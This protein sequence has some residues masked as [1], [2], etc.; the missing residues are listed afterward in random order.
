MLLGGIMVGVANPQ[1]PASECS[2]K[3]PTLKSC[4]RWCAPLVPTCRLPPGGL[5]GGPLR[6]IARAI[7]S[8]TRARRD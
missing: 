8:F 6:G 5:D 3:K 1:S 2:K 7:G 4:A